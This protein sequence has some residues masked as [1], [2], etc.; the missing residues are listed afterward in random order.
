MDQTTNKIRNHVYKYDRVVVGGTLEAVL[1]AFVHNLPI[2]Y[3]SETIPR[4]F[5]FLDPG[6]DL[7]PLLIENTAIDLKTFS[8]S[9]TIGLLKRDVWN[10]LVWNLSLSGNVLFSD[11]VRAIRLEA[12]N[13]IRVTTN[14]TRFAKIQYEELI[15]FDPDLIQNIPNEVLKPAKNL[16]KVYDWM[17]ITNGMNQKVDYLYTGDRFV[18]EIYL[19]PTDRVDGEQLSLKDILTISYLTMDELQ[20]FE[21]SDTYA[22]FKVLKIMKQNG[23]RGN[24]N[25][26]KTKKKV[27]RCYYAFK[28]EPTMREAIP[29]NKNLYQNSDSIK[30]SNLSFEDILKKYAKN[31][32]KNKY[33]YN[34]FSSLF[35][36]EKR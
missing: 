24:M 2:I 13:I 31:M 5:E 12:D 23:I 16:Y 25:G 15:V 28:V 29:I 10:R 1:Y 32:N 18:D 36:Y 34:L 33:I 9:K 35:S 30:F 21:Y 7:S 22:R 27:K 19:Y 6:I 20:D 26:W 14:N 11:K 4:F 8:G 3:D 17:N